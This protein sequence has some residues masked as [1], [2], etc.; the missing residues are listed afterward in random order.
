MGRSPAIPPELLTAPFRVARGAAL[1]VSAA[2]LRGPRFRAPFP[3]VRVAATLEDTLRVRAAAALVALPD[4][5]VLSCH[6]AAEVRRIP[7]P[8]EP[9]IHADIPANRRPTRICGIAAHGRKVPIAAVQGLPVCTPAENFLE[10]AEHLSLVDLVIAGDALVRHGWVQLGALHDAVSQVAGRR[11][12]RVARRGVG[13]VRARVDSP[14]E[15]RIRLLLVLAGLPCPEPGFRVLQDGRFIAY[16]DL[17][18][19]QYRVIIEYD[20]DLHRTLK[21]KWRMDVATREEL[22][23]LGWTVIVL[24][25]DDYAVWPARTVGRVARELARHGHPDVPPGW[26]TGAVD[27]RTLGA[28]WHA[29]F[30]GTARVAWDWAD[31]PPA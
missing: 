26:R 2:T 30:P 12:I 22:R 28:E 25:W 9:D 10:L 7:V 19:P 1:G 16:V 13:L 6:T 31:V 20:G 15:T 14:M 4:G 18:Y 11:G 23:D 21:K 17:A 27:A 5:S 24:T 3:G 29:A 8:T